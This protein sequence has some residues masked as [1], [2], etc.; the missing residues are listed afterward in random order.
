MKRTNKPG[1]LI[2]RKIW[3]S[4]Y[5][6]GRSYL[7]NFYEKDSRLDQDSNPDLQLYVP[8]HV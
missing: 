7:V 3:L 2:D 8:A 5:P 6:S 1:N 4:D